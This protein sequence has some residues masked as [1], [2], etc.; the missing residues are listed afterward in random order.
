MVSRDRGKTPARPAAPR[1]LDRAAELA[2]F[3]RFREHGDDDAGETLVR[4]N[5]AA[6]ALIARRYERYG[7]SLGELV[8]EGNFG[9]MQALARF[10]PARGNRFMTY[11][12]FWVRAFIVDYVIRSHSLV[13]GG[14]GALRSRFFFK[15]RRERSRLANLLGD[16]RA[17][18]RELAVRLGLSETKVSAML[19]RLDTRDVSLDATPSEGIPPLGERLPSPD[20]PER[21]VSERETRAL[22]GRILGTA[23]RELDARERYILEHR[24]MADGDDALSLAEI[25]R[26]LGVSRERARQLEQRT[27]QKLRKRVPES[28][29]Q[30]V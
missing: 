4:A 28:L 18:E 3:R 15:L 29:A 5:L 19:R 2:L 26:N 20:D 25:G 22:V 16:G 24:L 1:Q 27:K 14:S 9:L 23:V 13:G 21:A 17:V 6:V 11:A 10:D 8:S 30:G 7:S 12:S